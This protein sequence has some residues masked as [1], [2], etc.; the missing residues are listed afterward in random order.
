MSMVREQVTGGTPMY[1]RNKLPGDVELAGES[2]AAVLTTVGAGTITAALLTAG[3]LTRSGPVGAFIETT[4]TASN[5][6]NAMLGDNYVGTAQAAGSGGVDAGATFRLIYRNNEAFAMTLAAGTGVT[7]G[8]NVNCAASSVK[9]YLITVTN[10]TPSSVAVADT[11][12]ASAVITSMTQEETNRVSIGQLVTGT[13]IQAG[14]TVVAINPGIGVTLSL[15]ATATGSNV[16]LTF[17]PTVR[18][19]SL[20]QKLL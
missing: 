10:G 17:S 7:L 5:I 19:D 4:D 1:V 6:I 18:I 8:A 20:G 13:G 11:T 16:A 12:N 14:S 9:D 2:L 15:A 3:I